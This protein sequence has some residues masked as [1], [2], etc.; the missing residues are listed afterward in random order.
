MKREMMN[1]IKLCVQKP[2]R[3]VRSALV[4]FAML[5]M[6]ATYG[7]HTGLAQQP[8]QPTF[9]SVQ[10][11]S[12]TLFQAVQGNDEQAIANI[13]GGP[14]DLTSSRDKGQ[15]KLDRELFVQKYKEMHRLGREADGSMTLY[16]GA[17]NWPFPIPIVEKS[18][19]W[20]FDS[21]GGSKEVTFRRIGENEL[22]AMDICHE[23]VAA[24]K[25]N[26]ARPNTAEEADKSPA[27]LLVKA[28]SQSTGN[29]PMLFNGY[30]FKVLST[31]S[32]SNSKGGL[33][34][35]AY[36]AEYRSSGV[37]TFVVTANDVV[38]EK[39]LGAN[40]PALAGAMTAFHRDAT[41]HV[42]NE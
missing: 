4:S 37:M 22:T 40:T 10:E 33:A 1:M 16:I 39:D 15:D 24:K 21:D 30:Y 36:P 19:A 20:R 23:F 26:R 34:I 28:V 42:A 6:W 31:T 12:Q 32:T 2:S 14:T 35:I 25:Q 17:E 29:D 9:P 3:H 13:L 5:A 8:A 18:G 41:W 38:Y 27:S 7:P 11:A